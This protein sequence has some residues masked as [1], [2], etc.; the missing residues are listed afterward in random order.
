EQGRQGGPFIGHLEELDIR[1]TQADA[2]VPYL[3][4][5]RSL[6]LLFRP[7]HDEA[8]GVV[9]V[10]AGAQEVVAGGHLVA[11][12]ERRI[13]TFLDQIA[14]RAPFLEPRL[15]AVRLALPR[16]Q[17]FADPVYL[18]ERDDTI[19]RHTLQDQGRV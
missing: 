1:T 2:L 8:F 9:V 4:G 11:L 3:V 12:R 6:R 13:A 10:D 16:A 19:R 7:R 5:A 15:C 18:L 17:F 14:D